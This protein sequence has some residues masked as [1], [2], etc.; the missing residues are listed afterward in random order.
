MT[1]R[2]QLLE[3]ERQW[4]LFHESEPDDLGPERDPVAVLADLSFLLR[5]CTPEDLMRDP[6]PDKRGITAMREALGLA[7]KR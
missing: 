5:Y 3:R 7:S 6:D 4:Q 2:D 1:L